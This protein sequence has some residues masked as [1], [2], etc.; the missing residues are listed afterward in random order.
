MA[1]VLFCWPPE[2]TVTVRVTVSGCV[3]PLRSSVTSLVVAAPVGAAQLAGTLPSVATVAVQF[4]DSEL[5]SDP[6]VQVGDAL[7]PVGPVSVGATGVT[8]T[9]RSAD[10]AA[11][12]SPFGYTT[13]VYAPG[14]VGV[15][16]TSVVPAVTASWQ[17]LVTSVSALVEPSSRWS[18]QVVVGSSSDA[19]TAQVRALPTLVAGE[20]GCT[21]EP[22]A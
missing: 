9:G 15:K 16:L 2:V 8:L 20:V 17:A 3:A 10:T 21:S 7:G 13:S 12:A 14:S 4:S 18:P 22:S 19:S 5:S 6:M 1:V 11:V